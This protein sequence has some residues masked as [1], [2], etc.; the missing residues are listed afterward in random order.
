MKKLKFILVNLEELVAC[1]FLAILLILTISNVAVRFSTGRSFA[2]TEEISYGCYAWVVFVGASAVYKRGLHSS[3]D[4]VVQLLPEKI[5]RVISF[6]TSLLMLA[7]IVWVAYL[8]VGFT[9]HAYT[10]LTAILYIPYSYIDVSLVV[11]FGLMII[12]SFGFL[13]NILR[14][15]NYHDIPLYKGLFRIDDEQQTADGIGGK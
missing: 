4:L 11:G 12:H 6:C 13:R 1:V 7:A 5:Q 3:I 15:K 10:K 9:Y 14:Y 2:W 8:S